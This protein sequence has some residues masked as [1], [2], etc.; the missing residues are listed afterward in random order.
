MCRPRSELI[1][2]VNKL[3]SGSVQTILNFFLLSTFHLKFEMGKGLNRQKQS[4]AVIII[5]TYERYTVTFIDIHKYCTGQ[6]HEE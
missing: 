6:K 1:S 5:K 2:T 3:R 4:F